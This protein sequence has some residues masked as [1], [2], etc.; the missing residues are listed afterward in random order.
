MRGVTFDKKHTHWEWGLMLS[1]APAITSPEPKTYNVDIIGAHGSMNLMKALTGRVQYKNRHIR[2]EFVSMAGRDEWSAIYSSILAELHGQEKEIK[3]DD[4]P[5]HVYTGLVTVGDP[6]W[7]N[8]TVTLPITAEVEPFK[9]SIDGS[10][11][12]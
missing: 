6:T 11:M 1:K 12:L 10:V 4:D 2:M 5:M 3:L 8:D 7:E 9:K